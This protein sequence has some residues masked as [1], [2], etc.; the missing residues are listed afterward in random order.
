MTKKTT[1]PAPL[2]VEN[3][4]T[5]AD[6]PPMVR[7]NLREAL[8][9]H[10]TIQKGVA[11]VPEALFNDALEAVLDALPGA[12][13]AWLSRREQSKFW[14]QSQARIEAQRAEFRRQLNTSMHGRYKPL[15][16]GDQ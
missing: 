9:P 11:V 6:V 10:I 1:A 4:M 3:L 15:P 2:P 14:K 7:P 5:G 16:E 8:A 13:A 12:R